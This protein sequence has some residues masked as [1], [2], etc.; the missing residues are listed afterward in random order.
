MNNYKSIKSGFD[1][2]PQEKQAV[3]NQATALSTQAVVQIVT[4]LAEK[5]KLEAE[6][7]EKLSLDMSKAIENLRTTLTRELPTPKVIK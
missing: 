1:M 5:G 4:A 6:S 3:Y 2:T 7:L